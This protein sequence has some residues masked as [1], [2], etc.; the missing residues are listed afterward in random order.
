LVIVVL[1]KALLSHHYYIITAYS[2]E[3]W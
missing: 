1:G 3:M 2:Y